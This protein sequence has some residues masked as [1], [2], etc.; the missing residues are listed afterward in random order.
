MVN[1][2]PLSSWPEVPLA[3]PAGVPG[4]RVGADGTVRSLEDSTGLS[5]SYTPV[6]WTPGSSEAPRGASAPDDWGAKLSFWDDLRGAAERLGTRAN[7]VVNGAYSV[8]PGVYNAARAVGRGVGLLGADEFR[9]F[10]QEAEFA[11]GALTKAAQ[12]PGLA[13]RAA[14]SIVST[15]DQDPL[16]RYYM[17]GRALMGLATGMGPAAMAGDALRALETGHNWADAFRQ[18]VRGKLPTDP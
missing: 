15:L 17:A 16:F 6:R 10:D 18:G 2:I 3:S 4:F 12:H 5:P 8:F 9:R 1:I 14:G 11:G 13:Y 7:A